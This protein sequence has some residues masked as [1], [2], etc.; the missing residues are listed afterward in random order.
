[1]WR[2]LWWGMANGDPVK[3]AEIRKLDAVKEFWVFY[4]LWVQRQEEIIKQHKKN[5]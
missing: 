4:D 3:Y 1:M 5:K 2:E